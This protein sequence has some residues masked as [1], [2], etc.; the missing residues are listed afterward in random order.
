MDDHDDPFKEMVDDNEDD[1]AVAELVLNRLTMF[2]TDLDLDRLLLKVSN[3][4][5]QRRLGRMKQ[6]SISDFFEKTVTTYSDSDISVNFNYTVSDKNNLYILLFL[7]LYNT[8]HREET[9]CRCIIFFQNLVEI[10]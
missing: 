10:I 8:L 6:S 2:T 3:K 5:N 9:R 4:V 1:S 7:S